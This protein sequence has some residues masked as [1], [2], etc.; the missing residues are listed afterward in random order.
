[1][2]ILLLWLPCCAALLPL[3]PHAHM[4]LNCIIYVSSQYVAENES[5]DRTLS[6]LVLGRCDIFRFPIQFGT[7]YYFNVFLTHWQWALCRK[8]KK[9]YAN[10]KYASTWPTIK[11]SILILFP[12]TTIMERA[13]RGR[14]VERS[15]F[16]DHA[17]LCDSNWLMGQVFRRC[18]VWRIGREGGRAWGRADGD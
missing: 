5:G 11:R 12:T 13:H 9:K 8:K 2:D 17:H 3:R 15:P 1:M 16:S 18:Q 6:D 4:E 14:V 10:G 7:C